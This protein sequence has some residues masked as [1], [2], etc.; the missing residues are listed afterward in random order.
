V[1]E[2][3]VLGW[4][5]GVMRKGIIWNEYVRSSIGTALIRCEKID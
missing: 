3:S 2:I 5:S 1:A 4:M